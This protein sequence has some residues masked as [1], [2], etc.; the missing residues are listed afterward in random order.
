MVMLMPDTRAMW[1][2][3]SHIA[4][5]CREGR[6]DEAALRLHPTPAGVGAGVRCTTAVA[7]DPQRRAGEGSPGWGNGA[8]AS[9]DHNGM[10]V[11]SAVSLLCRRSTTVSFSHS[12]C[13]VS[14]Q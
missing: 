6:A 8:P 2:S 9:L 4:R 13:R 7:A 10:T 12:D 3:I 14:S 11:S 5:L 1:E